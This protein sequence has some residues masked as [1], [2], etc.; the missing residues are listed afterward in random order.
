MLKEETI[1]FEG[2]ATPPADPTRTGYTFHSWDGDY[3]GVTAPQ[4]VKA[5][6]TANANT[7]YT[8]EHY[9]QNIYRRWLY[10]KSN[11]SAV[12]HDGHSSRSHCQV[13]LPVSGNT[14]QANAFQQAILMATAHKC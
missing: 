3:T 7:V 8:V 11:R 4:T 2:D 10:L 9:Q 13:P 5:T 6:F 14:T 12:G 1:R